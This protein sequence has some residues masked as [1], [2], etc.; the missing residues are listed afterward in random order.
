M[1]EQQELLYPG[2][3]DAVLLSG[4]QPQQV[5]IGLLDDEDEVESK[6]AASVVDPSFN[7]P[8]KEESKVSEDIS[9]DIVVLGGSG[10]QPQAS[11]PI[12]SNSNAP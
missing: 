12:H 11:M 4:E 9:N 8:V 2:Y 6:L 1:N 7:A 5:A 10:N 3:N